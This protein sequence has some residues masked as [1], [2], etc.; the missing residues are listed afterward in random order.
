ML[1]YANCITVILIY[2]CFVKHMCKLSTNLGGGR[3][4]TSYNMNLH[5][6]LGGNWTAAPYGI[7]LHLFLCNLINLR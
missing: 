4:A 7:N 3:T 1:N 6:F 2:V 5:L